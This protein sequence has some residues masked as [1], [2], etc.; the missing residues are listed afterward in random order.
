MAIRQLS[1]AP[2]LWRDALRGLPSGGALQRR[3][4]SLDA[5]SPPGDA[6]AAPEP[7]LLRRRAQLATAMDRC[8]KVRLGVGRIVVSDVKAP[9]IFANM[10]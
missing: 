2:S 9:D 10:V 7:A 8:D 4:E 3:A 5:A 6:P 1:A